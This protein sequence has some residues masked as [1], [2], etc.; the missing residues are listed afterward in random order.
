MAKI[1]CELDFDPT[2]SSR[3]EIELENGIKFHSYHDYTRWSIQPGYIIATVR[4]V[5]DPTNEYDTLEDCPQEVLDSMDYN[6][7]FY[8]LRIGTSP[9][10]VDYN[11]TLLIPDCYAKRLKGLS[12]EYRIKKAHEY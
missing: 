7:Q 2:F 5:Y 9:V 8:S 6:P 10:I 11:G 1:D 12:G 4:E 3:M